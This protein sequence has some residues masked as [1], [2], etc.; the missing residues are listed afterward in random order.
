MTVSEIKYLIALYELFATDKSI[1]QMNL[2]YKLRLTRV[3][4]FKA[5][6]NLSYKKYVIKESNSQVKL[7]AKGID[8][9]TKYIVCAERI[10]YHLV[11]NLGSD[12]YLAKTDSL[13]IACVM[14]EENI[15]KLFDIIKTK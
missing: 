10:K 5:I 3:S 2:A 8:I 12:E 1:K 4:V 13:A 6:E 9:A 15:D 14:N 7:T 11:N